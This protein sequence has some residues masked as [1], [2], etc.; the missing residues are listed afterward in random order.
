MPI[1]EHMCHRCGKIFKRKLQLER[2]L[3]RK[4]KCAII[5]LDDDDG[6]LQVST[7][8]VILNKK[9]EFPD[10]P[11]FNFQ[12][13]L[14]ADKHYSI[15]LCAVRRSGKTTMIRHIYPLLLKLFDTVLFVSNS[16]HN[17]GVYNFVTGPSFPD[18]STDFFRDIF[19]FQRKS[20][21]MFR[22]MIVTDDCVSIK[23]KNDNGLLQ[24]F[25]RGRN[26]GISTIVSTQSPKLVNKNNRSNSDFV[27]IGNNPGEFRQVIVESFLINSVPVPKFI[28]TKSQKLDYLNQ[29]LI[30][31]T[32]DYG[33]III[34]N[35]FHKIY[36]FRTPI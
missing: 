11:M 33:F 22:I 36:K 28:K 9:L 30:H 27:I 7:D 32:K 8:D 31:H 15:M 5:E 12:K 13:E 6:I 34:D 23:R 2:H 29:W 35:R 14:E 4:N 24:V 19:R 25:L 3:N 17:Q 18:Y 21:N 16:I 1:T 10:L 20:N 26:S